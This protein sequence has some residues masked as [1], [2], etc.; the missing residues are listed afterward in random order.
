[1]IPQ[2]AKVD[3]WMLKLTICA[4]GQ[5]VAEQAK[6]IQEQAEEIDALNRVCPPGWEPKNQTL[7]C[8]ENIIWVGVPLSALSEK[9]VPTDPRWNIRMPMALGP[10][11]HPY[12][13][14]RFGE[15]NRR[16]CDF[17]L[18]DSA[19]AEYGIVESKGDRQK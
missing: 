14:K 19:L 17:T 18:S 13:A 2:G 9:Q 11:C 7:I 16:R 6:K 3:E 5:K 15:Q 12:M 1:M 4:L 10:R 8:A